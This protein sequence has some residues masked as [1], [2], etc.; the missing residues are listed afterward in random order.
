MGPS[1]PNGGE[2]D[3]LE[4]VNKASTNKMTLHTSARCVLD[5]TE[6]M[7]GTVDRTDCSSSN[8]NN[9]GCG[10]LDRNSSSS[11]GDGFNKAGGGVYAHIW[12]NEV[13][14]IWHFE[15]ANVPADIV[16][17]APDPTTWPTP[18]GSF[19]AGPDCDFS[20]HFQNHTL[21]IDTT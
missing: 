2:V 16:A 19:S 10:V 9:Q 11:Y 4:G 5:R 12:T 18:T 3:V 6:Q 15:R 7:M 17:G 14:Q 21:T 20:S 8:E 1:W 13:I